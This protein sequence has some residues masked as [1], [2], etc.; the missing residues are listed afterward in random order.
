[1]FVDG[2]ARTKYKLGTREAGPYKVLSR[3]DGTFSLDIGGYPETVSRDHVT[4]APR[5]PSDPQKLLQKIRCTTR[6]RGPRGASTHGQGV[7]L[8]GFRGP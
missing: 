8:G 2:H 7:R 3:E 5:H 1:V 4:A 6:H